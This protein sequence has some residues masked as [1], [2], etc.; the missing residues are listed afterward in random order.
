MFP[1]YICTTCLQIQS[2]YTGKL[3][4]KLCIVPRIFCKPNVLES[5]VTI[6]QKCV[7]VRTIDKTRKMFTC[8]YALVIWRLMRVIRTYTGSFKQKY[9]GR[10]VNREQYDF[11]QKSQHIY[12]AGDFTRISMNRNM[13]IVLFVCCSCCLTVQILNLFYYIYIHCV[14]KQALK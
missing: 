13:W 2:F 5:Y 1:D 4:A 8:A 7:E 11:F 9:I 12:P 6:S 14:K 10:G 3:F